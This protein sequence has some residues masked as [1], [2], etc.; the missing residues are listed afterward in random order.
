M[1]VKTPTSYC[2]SIFNLIFLQYVL[3]LVSA[4]WTNNTDIAFRNAHI[5][6]AS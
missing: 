6:L 5:Y 3:S 4:L 2:L 1:P